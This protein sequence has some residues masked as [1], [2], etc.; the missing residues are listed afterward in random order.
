MA[1][2]LD[3]ALVDAYTRGMN[4]PVASQAGYRCQADSDGTNV[5]YVGPQEITGSGVWNGKSRTILVRGTGSRTITLGPALHVGYLV[6]VVDA[7]GNAAGGDTIT[8]VVS[9]G[10]I[11]GTQ[12]IT[13]D[14]QSRLYCQTEDD[15]WAAIG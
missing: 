8:V 3:T 5:E 4:A 9:S 2:P 13:S 11:S 14:H 1:T 10:T 6:R 12:T 15:H 7:D